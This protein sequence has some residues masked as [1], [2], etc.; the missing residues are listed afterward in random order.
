MSKIES[1]QTYLFK[2]VFDSITGDVSLC[3]VLGK[4]LH[5]SVCIVLFESL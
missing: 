5:A 1:S 2:T 4:R 3:A